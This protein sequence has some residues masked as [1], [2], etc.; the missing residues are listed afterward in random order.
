MR[1]E[2][3]REIAAELPRRKPPAFL[4]EIKPAQQKQPIQTCANAGRRTLHWILEIEHFVFSY[5]LPVVRSGLFK[6]SVDQPGFF[7]VPLT[8]HSIVVLIKSHLL[9]VRINH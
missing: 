7:R 4:P 3:G 6:F 8:I 5:A 9:L 1:K 2:N